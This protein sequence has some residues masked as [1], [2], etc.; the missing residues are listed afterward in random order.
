MRPALSV[1]AAVL[2]I[3]AV[4]TG[5]CTATSTGAAAPYTAAP[6]G[7]VI[8][9][10]RPGEAARTLSPGE[11]ATAVPSPTAN[12][13]DVRFVQDMVVHHRQAIALSALAPTRASAEPLK[14]FAARIEDVQ[15][16]EI[17]M[18][19]AWLREQ[20]QKVPDHHTA[21][22]NMP[23]M[24]TPEQVAQLTAASGPAFDRL[25][26]RLM[27]VHHRGAI[28]MTTKVL[29]EG[30]HTR[31]QEIAEDISVTQAAEIGRMSRL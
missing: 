26:I 12:A 6:D 14:R 18:M 27:T 11:A 5:G 25:Y 4:L 8:A 30:A 16:P 13:A 3:T 22:Q 17:S 19:V 7:P 2:T 15:G 21:H 29:T 9:P 31:V 10:G 24:A 1:A 28:T 23:G 20:G